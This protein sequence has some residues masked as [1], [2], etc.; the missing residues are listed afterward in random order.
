VSQ[1]GT[2]DDFETRID[3]PL[4][5]I[6][7]RGAELAGL[8]SLLE[9]EQPDT[10][11]VVDKSVSH[12]DG[13]F[14]G[15]RSAV[16]LES[17]KPW[18]ASDVE[19]AIDGALAQYLTAGALGI[20]WKQS[21]DKLTYFALDGIAPL[22]FAI[23]GRYC[24]ISDDVEMLNAMMQKA[25]AMKSSPGQALKMLSGFNHAVERENFARATR[26]MDGANTSASTDTD[27]DGSGQ[28]PQFFSRNVVSLSRTFAAMRGEE[29]S[30]NWKNGA[31]H[32]TV[33]YE[34]K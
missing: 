16:L 29:V 2:E 30:E 24:M 19:A 14:V 4:A 33:R 7:P 26:L 11:L 20:E 32:Q 8:R 17:Q 13:V 1:A 27:S 15:Y 6:P 21:S 22:A 34:W 31:L 3:A 9:A 23:D 18:S 12:P 5:V 10:M 25:G 28:T